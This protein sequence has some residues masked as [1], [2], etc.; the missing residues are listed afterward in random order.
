MDIEKNKMRISF[1]TLQA[2]RMPL[3]FSFLPVQIILRF[4]FYNLKHV[5]IQQL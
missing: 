4:G 2:S 1:P 5:Y 3:E